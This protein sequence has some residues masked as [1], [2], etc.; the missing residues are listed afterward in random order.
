MSSNKYA[1]CYLCEETVYLYKSYSN[2]ASDNFF[3]RYRAV[4]K[5]NIVFCVICYKSIYVNKNIKI[6]SA[7]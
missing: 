7:F 1:N 2:K 3:N 5:H 6:N 4:L